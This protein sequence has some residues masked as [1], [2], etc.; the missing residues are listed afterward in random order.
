MENWISKQMNRISSDWGDNVKKFYSSDY[1]TWSNPQEH[2]KALKDDGNYYDAVIYLDWDKITSLNPNLKVLDLGAGT[3]WLS[4]FL[5]QYNN[6]ANIDVLDSDEK[7]LNL[8]LPEVVR[9]MGGNISKINPILGLFQPLLVED[10]HYD[11]IVA[12]S[13]L[14]HAENLFS[15]MRELRRVLRKGGKLYVLNETPYPFIKYFIMLL[16][17]NLF[18]LFKTLSKKIAEF[19]QAISAGYILYDPYLGDRTYA[20]Y[21]W[22]NAIKQAGFQ[23]EMIP[24]PFFPYKKRKNQGNKIK[25]FI[26]Y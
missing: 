1:S 20:N 6:I 26:C 21:Q 15:L 5:S 16:K 22:I 19:E 17:T 14:H 7:N 18:I 8:M 24:T 11:L 4:A 2:V 23:C 10:G 25:H 3:G 13:A 9:I 12:S